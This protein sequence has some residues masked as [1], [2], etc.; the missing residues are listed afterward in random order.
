MCPGEHPWKLLYREAVRKEAALF[1]SCS[2]DPTAYWASPSTREGHRPGGSKF[3]IAFSG[4]MRNFVAVWHSWLTNVVNPSG[5]IE[6]VHLFFHVWGDENT[7]SQSP[8]AVQSRELARSLTKVYGAFVEEKFTDHLAL[9]FS[10]NHTSWLA[11]VENEFRK[12]DI[13]IEAGSFAHSKANTR[14]RPHPRPF[15]VGPGYSQWR[16]VYLAHE[17]VKNASRRLSGGSET[18]YYDLIVRARPDH[19][20]VQ[21][22]DLRDVLKDFSTRASS[23]PSRSHFLAMPERFQGQT[24]T[25]RYNHFGLWKPGSLTSTLFLFLED[26]F[27][28]GSAAA[29]YRYAERPLPY[30]GACCE[31]YVQRNLHLRCFYRDANVIESEF[32][33]IDGESGAQSVES[34][35]KN[36]HN[37]AELIGGSNHWSL[38]PKNLRASNYS[39]HLNNPHTTMLFGYEGC[40]TNFRTK[41]QWGGGCIPVYRTRM[42]YI[43]NIVTSAWFDTGALCIGRYANEHEAEFLIRAEIANETLPAVAEKH[44]F[45]P[46]LRIPALGAAHKLAE[47]YLASIGPEV[48]DALKNP[49]R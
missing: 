1:D 14:P 29:M 44:R 11:A 19:S 33:G 24:F 9:L 4:G 30:T 3:A 38:V 25:G 39:A 40:P 41:P 43:Y 2:R 37:H 34:A 36:A 21:P 32:I 46:C 48:R 49:R 18:E 12:K 17:L 45:G 26:H 5:G 8:I 42:L 7:H 10:D 13:A 23:K 27:M 47:G 22:T 35:R 28:I 31:G 20:I 6:N 15:V 16:K